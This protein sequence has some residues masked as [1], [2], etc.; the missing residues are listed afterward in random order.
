MFVFR[1]KVEELT[2]R[3][4]SLLKSDLSNGEEI[5]RRQC[6]IREMN[7]VADERAPN[8]ELDIYLALDDVIDSKQLNRLFGDLRAMIDLEFQADL[9]CQP[10]VSTELIHI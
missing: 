10:R 5:L 7:V 2:A 6:P 9:A 8:G 1:V 4:R 3:S